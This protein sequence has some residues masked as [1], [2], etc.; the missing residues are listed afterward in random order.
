MKNAKMFR[1]ITSDFTN[2]VQFLWATALGRNTFP[3]RLKDFDA[4]TRKTSV[5]IHN[6]LAR[7]TSYKHEIYSALS[8]SQESPADD[9]PTIHLKEF[10][11]SGTIANDT[12]ASRT[13][14]TNPVYITQ[15]INTHTNILTDLIKRIVVA[16]QNMPLSNIMQLVS[17]E[18]NKQLTHQVQ[19][20][21][22]STQ[23][24]KC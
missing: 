15:T 4:S 18:T 5:V 21:D 13:N 9:T 8:A 2:L 1:E 16:N 14:E 24:V 10:D 7:F 19:F 6:M 12:E 22:P 23:P 3:N 17:N 20:S 11:E